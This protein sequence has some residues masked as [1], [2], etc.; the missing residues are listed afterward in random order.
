VTSPGVLSDFRDGASYVE[1]SDAK[2]T[3][4]TRVTPNPGACSPAYSFNVGFESV[5]VGP[6]SWRVH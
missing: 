2:K 3:W 1:V 4:Q 6:K 5:L